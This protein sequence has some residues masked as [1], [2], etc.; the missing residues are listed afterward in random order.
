M[1]LP[2][3]YNG[4]YFTNLHTQTGY[5]FGKMNQQMGY[6]NYDGQTEK[7]ELETLAEF[8]KITEWKKD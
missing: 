7:I 5:V 8:D 3:G 2:Q 4:K 1:T 6:M